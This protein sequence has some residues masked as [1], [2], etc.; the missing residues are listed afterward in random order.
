MQVSRAATTCR[1]KPQGDRQPEGLQGAASMAHE[2]WPRQGGLW[3]VARAGC[4]AVRACG[5]PSGSCRHRGRG[6]GLSL[7]IVR[8]EAAVAQPAQPLRV[9]RA[10]CQIRKRSRDLWAVSRRRDRRVAQRS[11]DRDQSAHARCAARVRSDTAP[12]KA[13]KGGRR[14][15]KARDVLH[16]RAIQRLRRRERA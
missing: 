10:R 8:L 3:G 1:V 12:A 16:G 7:V 9:G 14:R 13:R 2:P 5:A 11:P 6:A 15:E 4:G